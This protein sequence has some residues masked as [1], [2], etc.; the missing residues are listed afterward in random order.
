MKPVKIA[1]ACLLVLLT[2]A[3]LAAQQ[4]QLSAGLLQQW[5]SYLS[6]DE[7]E[8]RNT[9]S[10]GLGLAA[11]Y[12]ADQLKEGG[13]KPGGDR[14]SYLQRVAVLGVRT[15]N[16]SSVTVEV[17]GMT[18]TFRSGDGVTFRPNVG[19]KQTLTLNDVVFVGY[20]LNLN[21]NYNDYKGLDV[22][23][24]AVV[25][26]GLRGPAA[27]EPQ[28]VARQ[29]NSRASLAIDEMGAAASISPIVQQRLQAGGRG[30][31]NQPD[32]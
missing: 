32:F 26:I 8:G 3:G 18:R 10:E 21:G 27:S 1:A 23:G 25:W 15:V 5:L 22:K 14:G 11:A 6:S 28:R 16:R 2:A 30:G 19:G 24:K 9:F 17:N 7:L 20:G 29:L 12:I 31:G 4:S 13:V